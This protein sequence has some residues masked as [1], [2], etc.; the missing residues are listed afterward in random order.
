MV[1]SMFFCRKN[2]ETSFHKHFKWIP[3][4]RRG[5]KKKYNLL[6]V[7]ILSVIA[8]IC[9]A[10]GWYDMEEFGKNKIGFL[11]KFLPLESGIPSHDTFNRILRQ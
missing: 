9:G 8:V 2:M 7:I 4:P 6:E 1:L 3:D 11:Q 5:N 10:E